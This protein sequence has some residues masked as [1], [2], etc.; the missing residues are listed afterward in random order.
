MKLNCWGT[1]YF[2]SN[3]AAVLYYSTQQGLAFGPAVE[4]VERKLKEGSIHIGLP[5]VKRNQTIIPNYDEGRY[6]IE[7][8]VK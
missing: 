2:L 5:K 4:S 3:L 1:S 6:F 7:E 8:K